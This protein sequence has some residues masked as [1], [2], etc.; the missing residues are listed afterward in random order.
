MG[1]CI[2]F[3]RSVL[4]YALPFPKKVLWHDMW[5]GLVAERKGKTVFLPEQ[6]MLYRRHGNNAST[7]GEESAFSFAKQLQY[8]W[9]MLVNVLK[10]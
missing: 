4:D 8:R 2:A 10:R 7:T 3:R 1:S 5:I 6:L 9:V